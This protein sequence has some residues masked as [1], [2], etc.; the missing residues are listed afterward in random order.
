MADFNSI[1]RCGMG[2]ILFLG[3]DAMTDNDSQYTEL[4]SELMT[5]L[6]LI[7]VRED[8]TLAN[9][10]FDIMEKYGFEI[11]YGLKISGRQQ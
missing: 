4:T 8:S 2:G 7:E 9:Q 3:I 5:L 1:L 6:D 11:E 10:R